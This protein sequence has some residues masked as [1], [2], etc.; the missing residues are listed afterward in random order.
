MIV[1]VDIS[2]EQQKYLVLGE[3]IPLYFQGENI[4]GTLKKLSAGPH[5]ETRLYR[6]EIALPPVHTL[7]LGDIVEVILP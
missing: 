3:D 4:M 6:A 5:P 7:S 1:T 2:V